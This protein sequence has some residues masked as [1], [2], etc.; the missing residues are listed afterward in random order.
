MLRPFS[1]FFALVAGATSQAAP[2]G[3]KFKFVERM[4]ESQSLSVRYF[5]PANER[6]TKLNVGNIDS[7]YDY[8]V[9][10]NCNAM[11]CRAAVPV[12]VSIL[13][14]AKRQ[15]GP[16][17]GPKYGR[18]ELFSGRNKIDTI[19]IDYSGKCI[20]AGEKYFAINLDIIEFLRDH[21]VR[22]WAFIAPRKPGQ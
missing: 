18:I 3:G 14:T 5:D 10:L 4:E 21:G 2:A 16:C 19:Y 13:S 17:S 20:W 12:I 11:N 9:N 15:S 8:E 6:R 22:E 1:I 7:T